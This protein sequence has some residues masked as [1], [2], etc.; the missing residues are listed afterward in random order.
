M[1][2]SPK[3]RL[4]AAIASSALV[5]SVAATS[6][7]QQ[8]PGM[9]E[10]GQP[11]PGAPAGNAPTLTPIYGGVV[12]PPPPGQP[13]GGGNA[14]ESSARSVSG[15]QEDS[16]DLTAGRSEARSVTGGS[17]GPILMNDDQTSLAQAAQTVGSAPSV[18]VVRKGDTL[19]AICD[20]Y[21]RNPY[22]WPRIW[23]YNPQIQNPHWIYP[24]EQVRLKA[25]A[26][27]GPALAP[28][29]NAP[30][31]GEGVPVGTNR[32]VPADTVFLRDQG[33]VNDDAS[34]NWGSVVGAPEDK[35]F[36]SD[37]DEVYVRLGPG[38]D[39]KLGQ[40][41]TVYRPVRQ[42]ND[43][44]VIAIQ[45]TVQVDEWN[46]STRIARA[47]ITETL[48]AIERGARVGPI[49]RKFQVVAPKRNDADV[50]AHVA[51]AMHPHVFYGQDQLVFIDKGSEAGLQVGNRLFVV[52]RGDA[53]RHSMESD[54]AARRIAGER[55]EPAVMENTPKMRDDTS[56][57]EEV[58]AELRIL[59]VQKNSATCL[60][61]KST[62]EVEP[63]DVAVA[64]KGY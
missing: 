9:P 19:W 24:N 25:G 14:T 45:G 2:R 30:V 26:S 47:R 16:F 44:Q 43:G 34:L 5:S 50:T 57:P 22:Q 46:P 63:N 28:D 59:D 27:L 6:S 8:P 29:V 4:A 12:A 35:M 54:Q 36:L 17:N 33:F 32:M 23:S 62:Y 40:E 1:M 7:A 64:R 53:W 60:V 61:T 13:L 18:H 58:V 48:D 56:L 52:R 41:L 39:A 55:E 20:L 38:H 51:V 42:V 37:T 31:S 15:D 21:F 10:Q 11:S 49:P 3:L